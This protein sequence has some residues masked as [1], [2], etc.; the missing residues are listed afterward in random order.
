MTHPNE[1]EE[2]DDDDNHENTSSSHDVAPSL[3]VGVYYY[4]WYAGNFHGGKYPRQEL[5]P[6]QRPMLGEY[7]DRNVSV[8]AQHV[9]WSHDAGIQVWVTSWWGPNDQTDQ[10]LLQTIL[11]YLESSSTYP[12]RIAL[13]YET[14]GRIQQK[15]IDGTWDFSNIQK[16]IQY[17][18]RH[19]FCRSTSYLR[20]RERP[21]LFVYVTRSLYHNGILDTVIHFM[22]KAAAEAGYDHIYIVGDQ[23]WSDA[24]EDPIHYQP[25]QLLDG[26]TN[27][28][29]YGNLRIND[30]DPYARQAA[31]DQYQTRQAAWLQATRDS[32]RPCAFLPSITPGFTKR[33]DFVPLSRQLNESSQHGS[34]FQALVQNAFQVTEKCADLIVMITS[35]NEW[36]E[37]TQIEPMD[38]TG[39]FTNQPIN[40]TSGVTYDAYGELYLNILRQEICGYCTGLQPNSSGGCFSCLIPTIE[41]EMGVCSSASMG[42]LLGARWCFLLM[43]MLGVLGSYL[44][45]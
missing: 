32:K 18:S 22:R 41:L 5:V 9:Q 40:V 7:D 37:D 1:E 4:P 12:L 14:I 27:Y 15:Q 29:V 45:S 43:G 39:G 2:E 38:P 11:P 42:L 8:I 28:D 25:F 13:F 6:S 31:L 10:T 17:I 24:P 34:L 33:G 36:H 30:G 19:Y 44:V 21:V 26:V 20:I 3:R 16:D 23:V 35:W